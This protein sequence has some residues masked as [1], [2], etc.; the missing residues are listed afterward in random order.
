MTSLLKFLHIVVALSLVG[1]VISCGVSAIRGKFPERTRPLV[2]LCLCA[3]ASGS[4]LVIP[5]HYTFTTPWIMAAYLL[6]SFF[7]LITVL[8]FFLKKNQRFLTTA[9]YLILAT[10]LVI[11]IHDAV[12][13]STFLF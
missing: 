8:G 11:I 5:K 6:V 13:K 10:L 2:A 3:L 12:T 1:T 9:A 4:L 7:I